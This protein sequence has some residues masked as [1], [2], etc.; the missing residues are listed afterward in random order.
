VS[1]DVEV[2]SAVAQLAQFF[3]GAMAIRL[4]VTVSAH[5]APES[6]VIE[7]GT[8]HEVLFASALP[9]EFGDRVRLVNSDGSLDAEAVVVGVHYQDGH[10]AVAA[11]FTRVLPNW[12]IKA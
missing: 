6:T 5:Q 8:A 9:V 2:G 4:P 12:I 11:R 3:P 7:F 1:Q 10:K